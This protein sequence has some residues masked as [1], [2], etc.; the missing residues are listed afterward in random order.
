MSIVG[1]YGKNY[2]MNYIDD[3]V[4]CA[5]NKAIKNSRIW[6]NR[7]IKLYEKI[8]DNTSVALDIGSHLGTHTVPL[9]IRAKTVHAFEPQKRIFNLLTKTIDDNSIDNVI[10]HNKIVSDTTGDEI[11]FVNTDTGRA[12]LWSYRPYLKGTCTVETTMTIDSLE[13]ER[14]DFMKIDVEK[15]EW[16]VIRGA[17]QTI[18]KFKPIILIETFK[19]QKNLNQLDCF[20]KTYNY[21]QMY[22]SCNNYLLTQST[23]GM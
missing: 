22:I 23:A 15:A 16:D 17:R 21:Q 9:S 2:I 4:D 14:C 7:I 18:K 20:C 3:D 6:E 1:Y 19:T 13:L 12:G 5:V 8:I 11:S 10:L